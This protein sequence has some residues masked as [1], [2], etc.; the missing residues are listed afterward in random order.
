[1]QLMPKVRNPTLSLGG[2]SYDQVRLFRL[3]GLVIVENDPYNQVLRISC[4]ALG[5]A[6]GIGASAP[7]S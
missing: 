2:H 6:S 5:L 1:M 7:I 3:H 4:S